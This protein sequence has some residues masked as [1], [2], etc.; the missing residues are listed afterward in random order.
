[1]WDP[2]EA[3]L[4]DATVEWARTHGHSNRRLLSLTYAEW[5]RIWVAAWWRSVTRTV[6]LLFGETHA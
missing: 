3:D 2:K 4:V 6:R 1:M 5:L